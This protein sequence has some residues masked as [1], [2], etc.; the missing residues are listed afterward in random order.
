MDFVFMFWQS[1]ISIGG[2]LLHVLPSLLCFLPVC[3][4]CA[5]ALGCSTLTPPTSPA[6]LAVQKLH[7]I[8]TFILFLILCCWGCRHGSLAISLI[9][10]SMFFCASVEV[11]QAKRPGQRRCST[12]LTAP[13]KESPYLYQTSRGG[14]PPCQASPG[15]GMTNVSRLKDFS[16]LVCYLHVVLAECCTPCT[17][18]CPFSIIVVLC[19]SV[20]GPYPSCVVWEKTGSQSDAVR[21][22]SQKTSLMCNW[23]LW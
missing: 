12:V 5:L 2:S 15:A 13:L 1:C 7:L 23:L 17:T 18:H 10:N 21:I 14:W 4:L 11:P 19:V 9:D 20:V 22:Q 3:D 8:K 16:F 6:A